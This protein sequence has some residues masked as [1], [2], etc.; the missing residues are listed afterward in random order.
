[1]QNLLPNLMFALA[2]GGGLWG[3]A[4][5]KPGSAG[6]TLSS[7]F[8]AWGLTGLLNAALTATTPTQQLPSGS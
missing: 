1:M 2:V 4:K 7:A 5:T 3:A 8:A 6:H